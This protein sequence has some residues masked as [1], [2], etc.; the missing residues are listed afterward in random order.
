MYFISKNKFQHNYIKIKYVVFSFLVTSGILM[1][2]NSI[3][4]IELEYLIT[5][6]L[7][8]DFD[9]N[10][11]SSSGIH[12]RLIID[13]IKTAINNFKTFLVGNGFGTSFLLIHGYYWSGS[14]YANYHSLYVT[15]LVESGFLSMLSMIFFSFII[16]A[17]N[18]ISKNLIYPLI[19]G[20]FFYNIFYQIILEPIYWYILFY[21][22]RLNYDL[23]EKKH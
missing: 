3:K 19:I 12:L 17:Y 13:G 10:R 14:K 22:Y 2:L 20:L 18:K 21:Y 5:E 9:M 6:R 15:T 11:Y 7:S 4:L 1:Y 8:I 16:P 23:D